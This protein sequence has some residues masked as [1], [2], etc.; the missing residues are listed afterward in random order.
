VGTFVELIFRVLNILFVDVLGRRKHSGRHE[1]PAQKRQR[2]SAFKSARKISVLGVACMLVGAISTSSSWLALLVPVG[3]VAV[4]IA[5]L[6][7]D[8]LG[9]LLVG[10]VYFVWNVYTVIWVMIHAG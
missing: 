2:I 1:S 8:R 6:K 9:L 3:L 7:G 10:A 4:A 5:W